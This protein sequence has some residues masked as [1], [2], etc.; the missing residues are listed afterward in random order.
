MVRNGRGQ[1][2][3]AGSDRTAPAE[4]ACRPDAPPPRRRQGRDPAS[5]RA[6]PARLCRCAES[7]LNRRR[8]SRGRQA[9]Q[10]SADR[11]RISRPLAGVI[12]ANA[13]RSGDGFRPGR[14]GRGFRQYPQLG[15]LRPL[16]ARCRQNPGRSDRGR[17]PCDAARRGGRPLRGLA[18]GAGADSVA[19][20]RPGLRRAVPRGA[21]RPGAEIAGSQPAS[22]QL[23]R[24]HQR[25]VA[26]AR[27]PGRGPGRPAGRAADN[28]FQGARFLPRCPA[29]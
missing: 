22:H 13:P 25:C 15:R 29:S 12:S 27:S 24:S 28:R 6:G 2:H 26:V 16:Q 19:G 4:F 3:P 11:R 8:R 18:R 7:D 5:P 20:G 14:R 17:R 23:S 9:H 10:R 21:R 1:F